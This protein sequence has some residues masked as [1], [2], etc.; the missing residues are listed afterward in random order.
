MEQIIDIIINICNINL[1]S[2][3][4]IEI[5]LPPGRIKGVQ[6]RGIYD[7][8]YFSFERLPF[9]KPPVGELR[10]KAPQPAEGWSGVLDCTHY[11][12][13]PVQKALLTGE[14]DGN[15]DCLYL[16]VYAKKVTDHPG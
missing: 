8:E 16:N 11:A 15:E 13:K 14:I 6:R 1:T 2:L 9:G 3:E 4:T 5:A 7:D 12:S 10:F